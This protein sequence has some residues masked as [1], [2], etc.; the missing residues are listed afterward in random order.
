[1]PSAVWV[2]ITQARSWRAACTAEWMV[3]PAAFTRG[4]A[5]AWCSM[6]LPS[7]SIR[8]RSSGR[9]SWNSTP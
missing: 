4:G 5:P 3:K 8:T 9:I 1:M 2:W 7:A 6:T